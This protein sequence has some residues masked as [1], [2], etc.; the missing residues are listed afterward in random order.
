MPVG[1]IAS[2]DEFKTFLGR[3]A[4]TNTDKDPVLESFLKM[5]EDM[6]R[7]ECLQNFD[8]RAYAAEPHS[9]AGKFHVFAKQRPVAISPLP[10][11]T[12]NGTALTVAAGY[13]SSAHVVFDPETGIFTRQPLDLIGPSIT[14]GKRSSWAEG[15]NNIALSYT[16]G[17]AAA[18]MPN[19]LKLLVQFTAAFFWKQSDHKEVTV[20]RRSNQQG[21]TEFFDNLPPL[22]KAILDRYRTSPYGE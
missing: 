13:S 22:Y 6:I 16:G 18:D 3:E 8:Q 17:Y 4:K 7:G 1:S 21:T 11:V 20:K 5:A 19:D 12:E 15:N 9:G 14:N 2:L 10:V